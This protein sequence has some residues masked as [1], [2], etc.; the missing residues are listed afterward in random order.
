ML[1]M[2]LPPYLQPLKRSAAATQNKEGMFSPHVKGNFADFQPAIDV[3]L[4]DG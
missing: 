3:L 1:L 2:A 4:L